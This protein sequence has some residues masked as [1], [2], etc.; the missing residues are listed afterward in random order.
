MLGN[1]FHH[2]EINVRYL[3][4]MPQQLGSPKR[5]SNGSYIKNWEEHCDRHGTTPSFGGNSAYIVCDYPGILEALSSS[6]ASIEEVP[7]SLL[8]LIM[9]FASGAN[10][11]CALC[12][13][14]V[15]DPQE[16]K[17]I[18]PTRRKCKY[19]V[20]KRMG[21]DYYCEECATKK[22]LAWNSNSEYDECIQCGEKSLE[23]TVEF[24]HFCVGCER[25]TVCQD[26]YTKNTERF[27]SP[28]ESSCYDCMKSW[29]DDGW[30][31]D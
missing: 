23:V 1:F 6:T 21:T 31:S 26:C 19:M 30:Y 17:D 10:E 14:K 2:L 22:G 11:V 7:D 12:R 3:L 13:K 8:V 15:Y 9:Q 4:G 18:V 27:G 20:W 5:I 25:G 24:E 29:I 16:F 28:P